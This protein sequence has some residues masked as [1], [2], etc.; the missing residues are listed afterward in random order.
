MSLNRSLYRSLYRNL[1][2]SLE[3][4]LES[5]L[6]RSLERSLKKSL[7]RSLE[8][9]LK[10]SLEK[11]PI[12]VDYLWCH[13]YGCGRL[14]S[15][16]YPSP[17]IATDSDNPIGTIISSCPE[18]FH[19]GDESANRK[20]IQSIRR[21]LSENMSPEHFVALVVQKCMRFFEDD[22]W[23][24]GLDNPASSIFAVYIAKQVRYCY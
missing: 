6:E 21:G 15:V 24:A 14:T 13:S 3:R 18:R 2:R 20:L 1:K 22:P 8:R 17:Y 12:T 9:S 16:K 5:S 10:R 11:S 19:G 7:E 23:N 4:S